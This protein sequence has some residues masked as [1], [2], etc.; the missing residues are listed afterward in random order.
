MNAVLVDDFDNVTW[1]CNDKPL[2]HLHLQSQSVKMQFSLSFSITRKEIDGSV[3]DTPLQCPTP[4]AESPPPER[5]LCA[6]SDQRGIAQNFALHSSWA[7]QAWAWHTPANRSCKG[8]RHT[9]SCAGH[10]HVVH[11]A[12]VV[13]EIKGRPHLL[14]ISSKQKICL[15]WILH[16][17]NKARISGLFDKAASLYNKAA[18]LYNSLQLEACLP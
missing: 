12:E 11:R 14:I 5:C 9:V 1:L 6:T 8:S 18:S 17:A 3:L 7:P 16:E 15:V 4:S 10:V 2:L 13:Y